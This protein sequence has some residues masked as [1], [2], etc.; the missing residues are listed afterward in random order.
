MRYY[1]SPTT[2]GLPV[3][4]AGGSHSDADPT[5]PSQSVDRASRTD[6][7]PAGAFLYSDR[8]PTASPTDDATATR[9][10][11]TSSTG[12]TPTRLRAD[13][14]ATTPHEPISATTTPSEANL[15]VVP[16][17]HCRSID[18]GRTGSA[19]GEPPNWPRRPGGL[20]PA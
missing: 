11:G 6:G 18:P 10:S 7:A 16:G 1:A 20:P 19:G 12:P 2:R 4:E 13:G 3:R 8:R 14:D 5:S 9:S 17:G 15:Y